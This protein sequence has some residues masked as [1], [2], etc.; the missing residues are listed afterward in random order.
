LGDPDINNIK[1][2]LMNIKI[3]LNEI[4]CEGVDCIQIA[5]DNI[6][7]QSLVNMAIP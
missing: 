5:Q 2:I 4:G 7:W 6:K 3:D 1:L